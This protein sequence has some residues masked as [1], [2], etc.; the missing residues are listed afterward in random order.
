M[1]FKNLIDTI[2]ERRENLQV[3]QENLAKLSGVGLRTLKQFESGKGNPTLK[4]IQKLADVLGLEICLKVKKQ[5][6]DETS[7][8]TI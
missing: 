7:N 2:K 4:T 8:N 6:T 3:N 1:H 5:V